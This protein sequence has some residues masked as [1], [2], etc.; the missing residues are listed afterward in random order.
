MDFPKNVINLTPH[1]IKV[2]GEDDAF[3]FP[4]SGTVLRLIESEK[5]MY[6]N[7]LGIKFVRKTY[8]LPD[9]SFVKTDKT[10]IVSIITIPYLIGITG[11]FIAPDTGVKSVIRDDKGN[12]TGVRGFIVP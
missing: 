9:M 6:I 12:I 10:Y 1:A 7:K 3:V 2:V 11:D 8:S 5:V 4:A